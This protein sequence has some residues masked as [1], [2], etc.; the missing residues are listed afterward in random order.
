MI[1]SRQ[2]LVSLPILLIFRLV[3]SRLGLRNLTNTLLVDILAL[4]IGLQ[5]CIYSTLDPPLFASRSHSIRDD[6][7]PSRFLF[8]ICYKIED[9][10]MSE[11]VI[12]HISGYCGT[13]LE[14]SLAIL[15]GKCNNVSILECQP[16]RITQYLQADINQTIPCVIKPSCLIIPLAYLHVFLVNP[17]WKG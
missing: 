4:D 12:K 17:L 1:G 16:D 7:R 11:N 9:S 8:F 6:R 14:I 13:H 10:D 5:S 2:G 3:A 15:D